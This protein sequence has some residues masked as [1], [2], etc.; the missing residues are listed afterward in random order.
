MEAPLPIPLHEELIL[1]GIYCN[2]DTE[3]HAQIINDYAARLNAAY[4]S[5]NL[6]DFSAKDPIYRLIC[7]S[8]TTTS[9]YLKSI[10]P[11]LGRNYTTLH[12]TFGGS[13]K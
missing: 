12:Y 5:G 7:S 10:E 8:L 1:D 3:K 9:L 6:T 4:F 11:D 2:S 13:Q